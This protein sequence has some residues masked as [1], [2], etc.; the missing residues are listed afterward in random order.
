VTG[1]HAVQN[2]TTQGWWKEIKKLS[3]MSAV[4]RNNTLSIVQHIPC[5]SAEPTPLDI[6]NVINNTFLTPVSDLSPL[7]PNVRLNSDNET[8]F[9]VT[10]QSVFQKLLALNP[11]KATGPDGIPGW[12]LKENADIIAGPVMSIINCSFL[13]S[14]LPPSW[15]EA[16]IV[17]I[18]KQKPVNDVNKDQRAIS[19]TPILSKVGEEYVVKVLPKTC[20]IKKS[21]S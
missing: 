21:R 16:D 13:E 17:P 14:R 9:T 19:L 1:S 8:A 2:I 4:T 6:A 18:P 12:L 15:K 10:E 7:S 5:D 3:G 11:T 20:S